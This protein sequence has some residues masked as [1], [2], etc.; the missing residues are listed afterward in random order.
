MCPSRSFAAVAQSQPPAMPS[1][2]RRDVGAASALPRSTLHNDTLR[3]IAHV[4]FGWIRDVLAQEGADAAARQRD[5]SKIAHEQGRQESRS[6]VHLNWRMVRRRLRRVLRRQWL[7][8]LAGPTRPTGSTPR[9]ARRSCISISYTLDDASQPIWSVRRQS[10]WMSATIRMD[11]AAGF[12]RRS[13][14][15]RP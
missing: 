9:G 1:P 11:A 4:Q 7:R 13:G 12:G 6:P 3:I 8:L 2:S 15:A 10:G 14:V 5:R